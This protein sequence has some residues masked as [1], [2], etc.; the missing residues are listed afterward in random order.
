MERVGFD[1][2]PWALSS[3]T[4]NPDE[5]SKESR[6]KLKHLREAKDEGKPA[7]H[8]ADS[9]YFDKLLNNR[10]DKE[11][12]GVYE[13]PG[14]ITK[15][16]CETIKSMRDSGTT[17]KDVADEFEVCTRTIRRHESDECSHT[18]TFIRPGQCDVMRMLAEL[19][20]PLDFI[21]EF[22]GHAEG[23]SVNHHIYNDCSCDNVLP[24]ASRRNQKAQIGREECKK[25][26]KKK[27][28]GKSEE[29]IA[30]EHFTTTERVK[31]HARRHCSH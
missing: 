28:N 16:D 18:R 15:S 30:D 10:G 12:K 29:T 14:K 19:G 27:R 20:A 9:Y 21:A 1:S 5:L 3:K 22:T 31:A 8:A 17:Q 7:H 6:D 25:M 13:R 4:T 26:R 23:S 11:S 2:L 24:P